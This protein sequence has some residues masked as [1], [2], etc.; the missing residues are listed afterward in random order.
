MLYLLHT[1]LQD[2][3]LLALFLSLP[4]MQR[5]MAVC[6]CRPAVAGYNFALTLHNDFGKQALHAV[7]T[8]ILLTIMQLAEAANMLFIPVAFQSPRYSANQHGLHKQSEHR[9]R[10]ISLPCLQEFCGG[11]AQGKPL[12]MPLDVLTS[13]AGQQKVILGLS[14]KQTGMFLNWNGKRLAY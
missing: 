10:E 12:E 11:V 9:L 8:F 7:L 14:Q 3:C 6:P 13:V 5:P 4:N 1:L 2:C